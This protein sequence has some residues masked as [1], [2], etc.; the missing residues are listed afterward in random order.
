MP[1]IVASPS[2]VPLPLGL[3]VSNP[4]A[5]TGTGGS[6]GG[7]KIKPAQVVLGVT[8]FVISMLAPEVRRPVML[9]PVV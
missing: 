5:L 9:A 1:N 6:S 2:P 3:D 4:G 8:A 7:G